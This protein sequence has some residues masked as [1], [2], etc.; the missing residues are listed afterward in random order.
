MSFV[1][2]CTSITYLL[3]NMNFVLLE[4]NAFIKRLSA[5]I[6]YFRKMFVG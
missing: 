1:T 6:E 4:Q 2:L 3:I 5:A